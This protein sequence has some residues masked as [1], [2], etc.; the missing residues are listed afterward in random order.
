MSFFLD[1]DVLLDV[2]LERKPLAKASGKLLDRL[3]RGQDSAA[4][5]WHWISNLCARSGG[6]L[7][8]ARASSRP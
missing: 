8:L 1:C 6:R 7:R 2:A 5:A 4:M 3:E